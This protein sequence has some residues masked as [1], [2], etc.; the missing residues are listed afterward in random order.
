MLKWVRTGSTPKHD[1]GGKTTP[2]YAQ[3]DDLNPNDS[4]LGPKLFELSF[5]CS[6]YAENVVGNE[7]S[8]MDPHAVMDGGDGSDSEEPDENDDDEDNTA[9][10]SN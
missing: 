8:G 9:G 4:N 5:C 3:F 1:S 10:M 2:K 7:L 6:H